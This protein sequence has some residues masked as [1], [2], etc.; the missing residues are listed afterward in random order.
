MGNPLFARKP[1]DALLR[2]AG[3]TTEQSLKRA[4]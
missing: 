4:L 1:L 2:E 3:D